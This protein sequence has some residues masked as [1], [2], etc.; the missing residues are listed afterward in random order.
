MEERPAEPVL[1]RMILDQ[2][3]TVSRLAVLEGAERTQRAAK[4][5]SLLVRHLYSEP[6]GSCPLESEL[7]VVNVATELA[8]IRTGESVELALVNEDRAPAMVPRGVIV[9]PILRILSEDLDGA[10]RPVLR[11][12]FERSSVTISASTGDGAETVARERLP[13]EESSS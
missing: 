3:N 9:R 13:M 4:L 11:I 2:L 7:R 1:I 10:P 8:G 12:D 5:A 6:A